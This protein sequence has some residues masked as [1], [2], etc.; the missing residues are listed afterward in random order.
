MR[1]RLGTL[2]NP[3]ATDSPGIQAA[4]LL[5]N[6]MYRAAL[7][8]LSDPNSPDSKLLLA[9]LTNWKASIRLR[10]MNSELFSAIERE[11]RA[12]YERIVKAE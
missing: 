5:A 2:S 11:G 4:D 3:L 7:R 12:A 1:A 8:K 10:L 6:R 9:L